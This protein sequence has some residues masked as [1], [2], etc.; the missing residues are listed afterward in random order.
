MRDSLGRD[1]CQMEGQLWGPIDVKAWRTVPCLT[2]RVATELDVKA[3]CAVF[4]APSGPQYIPNTPHPMS[5]PVAAILK[6]DAHEPQPL[7]V[8]VIQAEV[9][10]NS[11]LIGYRPIRGGNGICILSDLQ[12]LEEPDDRFLGAA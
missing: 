7:P 8:I 2:G 12:L 4:Y 10:P 3:G 5:L 9:G 6:P 1:T 11:I